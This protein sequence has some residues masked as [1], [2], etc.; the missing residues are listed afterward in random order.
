MMKASSKAKVLKVL[1]PL[2]KAECPVVVL[3][4]R[5][6][7]KTNRLTFIYKEALDYGKDYGSRDL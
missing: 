5:G 1:R 2:T 7:A 4:L 6:Y 3:I